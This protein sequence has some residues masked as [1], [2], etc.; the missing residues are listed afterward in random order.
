M[1]DKNNV[2]IEI[3]DIVKIENSP[4]KSDN[5]TYVV[6]QDGTS[7]GYSCSDLTLYKVAKHKNG[8]SLSKSSYNICF[9]PLHNY[10]SKY[11]YTREEMNEEVI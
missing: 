3:G 8:Y 2:I 1:N 5:A 7:K 11:H 4:I 10:S 6:G 9:Y